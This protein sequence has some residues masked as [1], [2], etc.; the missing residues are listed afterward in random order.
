ML[1]NF[2]PHMTWKSYAD[3]IFWPSRSKIHVYG[4][5]SLHN[6][7]HFKHVQL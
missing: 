5:T 3:Q 4:D 1:F 2:I 7:T 6:I